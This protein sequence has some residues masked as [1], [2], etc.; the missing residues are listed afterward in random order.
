MAGLGDTSG[1]AAAIT[2]RALKLEAAGV[3]AHPIATDSFEGLASG[4]FSVVHGGFATAEE[5]QA[6]VEELR[7]KKIK[8]YAKESGPLRGGGRLV[9]IRGI[10]ARNGARGRWPLLVTTDDGGEGTIKSAANGQFVMWMATTGK[11][12]IQNE[13]ETPEKD[14]MR[15]AEAL[16]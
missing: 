12:D 1:D 15:A 3:E 5:A 14:N 6:R 16:H 9:E 2:A 4:L 11:L 13:A 7:P 10:A 8:A